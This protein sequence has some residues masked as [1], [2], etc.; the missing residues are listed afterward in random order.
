MIKIGE[1]II[2]FDWLSPITSDMLSKGGAILRRSS[3][4]SIPF[5]LVKKKGVEKVIDQ[6][7]G[8]D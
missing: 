3:D 4:G 5:L 6:G 7:K 2:W 1:N 8:I